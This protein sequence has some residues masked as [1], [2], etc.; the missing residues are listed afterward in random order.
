[1][2]QNLINTLAALGLIAL[3]WGGP[4]LA[5][6]LAYAGWKLSKIRYH[7]GNPAVRVPVQTFRSKTAARRASVQLYR[8]HGR[9]F[10]ITTTR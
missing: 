8:A 7:V 10:Q 1:M 2:T 9:A 5:L 4:I 3:Y 6:T